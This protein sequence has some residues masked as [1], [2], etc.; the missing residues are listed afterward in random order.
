MLPLLE[1]GLEVLLIEVDDVALHLL[2]AGL[3]GWRRW[4]LLGAVGTHSI[5]CISY[6]SLSWSTAHW[7]TFQLQLLTVVEH[8]SLGDVPVIT[9]HCCAAL[10]MSGEVGGGGGDVPI[11]I[12]HCLCSTAHGWGGGGGGGA[13]QLSLTVVQH[14]SW[15]GGTGG[16]WGGAFQLVSLTVVLLCST[17]LWGDVP[18]IISHSCGTLLMV[19][20]VWGCVCVGGGGGGGIPISIT[21]C[22]TV[23]QHSSLGGRSKYYHS[24]LW[25]TAHGG[26]GGAFPISITHCCTVVQHCSLG[27]VPVIIANRCA[28]LLTRGCFNYYH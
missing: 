23:V 10:L 6:R 13:F 17:A 5:T 2:P 26:G 20:G 7:G 11:I 21:H 12:A 9:N 18:N 22:C 8:C 19:G 14:C 4:G 1:G 16:G 15:G 27:A 25:N 28:A 24:L 3:R